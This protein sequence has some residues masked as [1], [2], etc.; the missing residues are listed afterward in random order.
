MVPGSVNVSFDLSS[1]IYN[2]GNANDYRLLV[3]NFECEFFFPHQQPLERLLEIMLTFSGITFN[4]GDYF[5]SVWPICQHRVAFAWSA[6]LAQADQKALQ[7]QPTSALTKKAAMVC[8]KPIYS[9]QP[10]SHFNE[11]I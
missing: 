4:D 6:L 9:R 2:S 3:R 1:A 7:V 11:S 10:T 8:C 5:T